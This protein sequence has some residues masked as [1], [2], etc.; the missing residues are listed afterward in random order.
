MY[1][2]CKNRSNSFTSPREATPS[3]I[4]G[5]N[6]YVNM[7]A[8]YSFQS[9]LRFNSQLKVKEI[10][11]FWSFVLMLINSCSNYLSFVQTLFM[12]ISIQQHYSWQFRKGQQSSHPFKLIVKKCLYSAHISKQQLPVMQ[13][14]Q[15][16]IKLC[17]CYTNFMYPISTK[18]VQSL[19]LYMSTKAEQ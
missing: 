17:H 1:V 11:V 14:R 13:F 16:L 15:K 12:I 2:Q 4:R 18:S 19:R 7:P 3:P 6:E 10:I 8:T 5:T 9:L